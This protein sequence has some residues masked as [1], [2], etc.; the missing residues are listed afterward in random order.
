MKS[1]QLLIFILLIFVN[2]TSRA[3]C[4]D[5]TLSWDRS[6]T[7]EVSG[8]MVYYKADN[9]D[10]PFD[11]VGAAEGKSPIDVKDTLTTTLT[12]LD[13]D[14]DYFFSVT[15]Y[16]AETESSFSNIVSTS[17]L[18]ALLTPTN[19]ATNEPDPATFQWEIAPAEYIVTYTL[20]YGTDKTEVK[21]AAVIVAPPTVPGQKNIP[22]I[23][24]AILAALIL[25]ALQYRPLKKVPLQAV[26]LLL[27]LLLGGGLT[28][29]GGGG[30]GDNSDKDS[31]VSGSKSAELYSIDKGNSDYHEAYDLQPSTT[32]YWKVV[33]TDAM[34]QTLSYE[35]E[36]W[37]FTTEKF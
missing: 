8:Y 29:C 27:L 34:D 18:P 37:Q 32:Y 13:D 25:L 11:G 33:A 22:Q 23:I 15:A 6:P 24:L 30:G 36:V 1:F 21:N 28:A 4:Q 12:D 17:W 3:L 19:G 26:T 16:D 35:S 5:V 31:A 10:L 20:F 2:P 7:P 14:V 9:S